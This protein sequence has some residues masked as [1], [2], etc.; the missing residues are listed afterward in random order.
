MRSLQVP[1]CS[2]RPVPIGAITIRFLASSP[3]IRSGEKRSGYSPTPF[4]A[5]AAAPTSSRPTPS[6]VAKGPTPSPTRAAVAT[7]IGRSMPA[8]W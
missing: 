7:M 2:G 3:A 4:A 5:H 6:T 8:A 1:S